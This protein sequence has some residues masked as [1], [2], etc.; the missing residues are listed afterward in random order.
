MNKV[1]YT[2]DIGDEAP[3]FRLDSQMGNVSFHSLIDGKWGLLVTFRACFDP[4]VT[5]E[6][7]MLCKLFEEFEARNIAVVAIGADSVANYRRW[8]KDIEELQAVKVNIP[9]IS[10]PDNSVLVALGTA[11]TSQFSKQIRVVSNGMFLID[12]DKRIRV[13]SRYSPSVGRNFYEPIRSF[14]ALQLSTYHRVV[15]PAN[16]GSGQDVFVHNEV[17]NEEATKVLPKGFVSIKPW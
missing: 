13:S 11:R 12:L 9:I 2:L 3:D 17:S 16:W 4:V 7:G 1:P 5:T 15:C 14:D 10:D 6:I 8:I